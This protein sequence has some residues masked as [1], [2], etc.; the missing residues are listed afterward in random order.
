MEKSIV[1]R[2]IEGDE[3]VGWKEMKCTQKCLWIVVLFTKNQWPHWQREWWVKAIITWLIR[4][5]APR[6]REE[7]EDWHYTKLLRKGLQCFII[8]S[9]I[10]FFLY[11]SSAFC[12]FLY[13]KHLPP[14]YLMAHSLASFNLHHKT[15]FSKIISS[16]LGSVHTPTCAYTHAD[17]LAPFLSFP[18]HLNPCQ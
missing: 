7:R 11:L 12:Y 17:L 8:P 18:F 4:W 3:N 1:K 16:F 5:C 13:L 15:T 10:R 14:R 6:W 9:G 2:W